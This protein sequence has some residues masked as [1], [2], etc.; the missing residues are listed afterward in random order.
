MWSALLLSLLFVA[1][2]N[3]INRWAPFHDGAYAPVNLAFAAAITF[4]AATTLEL[5]GT[6]L[7]FSGDVFDAAVSFAVVAIFAVGAL[8]LARSRYGH[9]IADKRVAGLRGAGLAYHLLARIPLGTAV[10]EELLFRGL[11]FAAWREAGLSMLGAALCASLAFGLWHI[12]PT[13]LGVRINDPS[14]SRRK[15]RFTVAG[16][17]VATTIVGL[18]LTWL[19]VTTDGLLVPIVLHGGINSTAAL[20]AIKA[21]RRLALEPPA[22]GAAGLDGGESGS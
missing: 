14:A 7:G 20:A 5:S 22:R 4:I 12:L 6:E 3:V 16:A 15:I 18:G 10:T 17:V 8:A 13:I 1:Y 2:N 9:R 21:G 11:L 19:R